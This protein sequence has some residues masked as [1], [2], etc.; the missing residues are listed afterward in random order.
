M[1]GGRPRKPTARKKR[2]GTYR[3]DR[4]PKNELR[5][6]AEEPPRPDFLDAHAIEC[7][8]YYA[9]RLVK[10]GLL[11]DHDW[12][13]FV[14]MCQAWG[15][16]RDC[17]TMLAESGYTFSTPNGYVQQ[18][19]EV[20]ILQQAETVFL[21]IAARFG[22]DPSSR[23]GMDIAPPEDGDA[24]AEFLFGRGGLKLVKDKRGSSNG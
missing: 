9:P 14:M 1:P 11:T 24:D 16:K 10:A 7:W 5:P 22:L 8:E 3:K 23:S 12:A 13:Q 15:R 19:P 20:S 18:R 21:K 2:E 4:A 17:E 6:A